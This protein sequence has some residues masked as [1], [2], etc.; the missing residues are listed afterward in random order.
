MAEL[1]STPGR[2]G[3][4]PYVGWLQTELPDYPPTVGLKVRVQTRPV[5]ERPTVEVEPSAHPLV[6]EQREGITSQRVREIAER[7]LHPS[8]PA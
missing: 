7:L 2:E 3:E 6:R 8:G 5:G 4:P 1:W